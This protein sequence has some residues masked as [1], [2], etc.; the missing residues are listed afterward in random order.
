MLDRNENNLSPVFRAI[1]SQ[2]RATAKDTQ[3]A[4]SKNLL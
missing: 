4:P 3:L 1:D 2:N